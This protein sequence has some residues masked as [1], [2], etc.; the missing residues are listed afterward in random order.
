MTMQ[1]AMKRKVIAVD[2]DGVLC[3]GA[4]WTVEEVPA[5]KPREDVIKK[6]NELY[7]MNFVV[8]Y[9][10]RRDPLIPATLEWL[11]RNNVRF[12]AFSNIKIGA[13]Q[14]IDDRAISDKD[15]LNA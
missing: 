2:L 4:A 7:E 3:E 14:Y 9:T 5:M 15:F 8:I 12:H 6:V 10:A 11:R 13:E 1:S